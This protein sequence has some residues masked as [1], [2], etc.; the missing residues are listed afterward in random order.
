MPK[1]TV[2]A[3]VQGGK[4]SAGP[5]LGPQ[6]GPLGVKIPD[7]IAKINEKTK[8]LAGIDVPIKVIVNEDKSFDIEVG[9][10]PVSS[11]IKTHLKLQKGSGFAGEGRAGDLTPEQVKAIAR[12]KFG[13]DKPQHTKQVE[14]SARSMGISIGKGPVTDEEKKK[15][16]ELIKAREAEKAK[17]A[18]AKAP[19]T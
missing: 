10:P 1:Q 4:A 11:L 6:L 5:P 2:S 17:A 18:A 13:S 9:T 14:G 8:D 16:E 12:T 3:V 19:K 7:I 15:L